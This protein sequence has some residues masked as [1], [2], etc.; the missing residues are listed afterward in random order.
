MSGIGGFWNGIS[1]IRIS[2]AINGQT[3][4]VY[5][6]NMIT[7]PAR[8]PIS[9]FC[10]NFGSICVLPSRGGICLIKVESCT[11]W[12]VF[13]ICYGDRYG[14]KD[15]ENHRK[16]LEVCPW[17]PDREQSNMAATGTWKSHI[18]AT[19]TT[20]IKCNT[21]FSMFLDLENPYLL[22]NLM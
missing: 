16:Q 15:S 9:D 14:W 12:Q 18:S 3:L 10:I 6:W 2:V 7:F 20:R 11:W 19:F 13:E 21:N 8:R 22:L 1:K 17:W 5:S 4:L